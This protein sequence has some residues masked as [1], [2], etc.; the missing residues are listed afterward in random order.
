M[1]ATEI[2]LFACTLISLIA[3][4]VMARLGSGSNASHAHPHLG[5]RGVKAKED[6]A[7]GQ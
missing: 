3:L 6:T 1:T 2:I 5:G 7:G 4:L